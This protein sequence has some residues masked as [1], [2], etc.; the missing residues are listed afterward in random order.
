L[1]SLFLS[2]VLAWGITFFLPS[3]DFTIIKPEGIVAWTGIVLL[4][5]VTGYWEEGVFRLYFLT[6]CSRAGI[7]NFGSVLASSLVFAFCHSYEGIPGMV[8]AGVAGITLSVIYL[9][10][11]SYHGPALAHAL[12]NM[13][14]Y[15]FASETA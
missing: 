11:G 15:I 14:A 2:S 1:G 5:L 4:C 12:Y 7:R 3:E 9:K 8:N 13:A 10:T 6:I